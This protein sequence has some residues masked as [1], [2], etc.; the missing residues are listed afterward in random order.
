MEKLNLKM[1][2]EKNGA[3]LDEKQASFVE[4]LQ[5]AIT[6]A[7]ET[8]NKDVSKV[9]EDKL[10]SIEFKMPEQ[11][12]E[13]IRMLGERFKKLE[14]TNPN[15]RLNDLQKMTL[16]HRVKEDHKLIVDAIKNKK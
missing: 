15:N 4:G 13:D 14:E 7:F 8:N 2:L 10:A 16:K 12:V 9:I 6:E 11:T 5:N 3:V 1:A